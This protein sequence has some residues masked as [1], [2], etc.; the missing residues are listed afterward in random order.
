MS[1]DL[2]TD[3]LFC[4][5]RRIGNIPAGNGGL[6]IRKLYV[7][8]SDKQELFVFFLPVSVHFRYMHFEVNLL[9]FSIEITFL[10]RHL[11]LFGDQE[12]TRIYTRIAYEYIY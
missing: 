2:L 8:F 10:F 4:V 9:Y 11:C 1:T 3:W 12:V 7:D 6:M 5:L